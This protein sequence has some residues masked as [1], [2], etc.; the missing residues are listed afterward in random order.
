MFVSLSFDEEEEPQNF[1]SGSASFQ[2][3]V[4][5]LHNSEICKTVLFCMVSHM[6]KKREINLTYACGTTRT[7]E[8]KFWFQTE[9]VLRQSQIHIKW[10]PEIRRPDHNA[11]DQSPSTNEYCYSHTVAYVFTPMVLIKPRENFVALIYLIRCISLW[12]KKG[13]KRLIRWRLFFW[14]IKNKHTVKKFPTF[15]EIKNVIAVFTSDVVWSLSLE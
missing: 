3:Y 5:S 2:S 15:Y 12:E 8:G 11:D 1:I 13:C 7:A 6:P 10:A 9:T 14:E 4:Y